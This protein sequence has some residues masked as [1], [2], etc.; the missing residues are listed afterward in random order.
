MH[1]HANVND[2][3]LSLS[4][5][6]SSL[7]GYSAIGHGVYLLNASGEVRYL[8]ATEARISGG[9]SNKRIPGEVIMTGLTYKEMK[10]SDKYELMR[11]Y[12]EQLIDHFNN[13]TDGEVLE[14]HNKNTLKDLELYRD[15]YLEGWKV[16]SSIMIIC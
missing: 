10:D 15:K 6:F 3:M 8:E 14:Y 1:T 2:D 9:E 7:D 12:G 5:T 13:C 16:Q 4:N 11:E